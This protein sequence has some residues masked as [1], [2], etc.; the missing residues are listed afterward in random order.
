MAAGRKLG[1][2]V[3]DFFR[4]ALYNSQV[5]KGVDPSI[6]SDAI[7]KVDFDYDRLTGSRRT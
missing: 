3:E 1:T 7:N 4:G 6:A 2:N 5:R